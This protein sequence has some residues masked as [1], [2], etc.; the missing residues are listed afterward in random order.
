ML[1]LQIIGVNSPFQ[2][3]SSG[4][5]EVQ[6]DF[7]M[8]LN[9][10]TSITNTYHIHVTHTY[11]MQIFRVPNTFSLLLVTVHR[12]KHAQTFTILFCSQAIT[13]V[14]FIT[15]QCS[16]IRTASIT[17]RCTNYKTHA[18]HYLLFMH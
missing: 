6:S 14:T 9:L 5:N 4:V 12:H 15:L 18:N 17:V 16:I 1:M 3:I 13:I 8:A 10:C 2:Y 11:F 7:K